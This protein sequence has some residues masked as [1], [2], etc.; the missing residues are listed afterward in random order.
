MTQQ[1]RLLLILL[2]LAIASLA[3]AG[4]AMAHAA[5]TKTVPADGAVVASAPGELSLSFSE[6]VSPLVLNL[7]G[8]DGTIRFSTSGETGSLKLRLSSP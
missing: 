6:P 3:T 8:P 7:I 4:Q 5:L 2:G 1:L